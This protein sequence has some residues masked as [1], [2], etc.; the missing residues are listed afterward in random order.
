MIRRSTSLCQWYQ[1]RN[2][3]TIVSPAFIPK[4]YRPQNE[5]P[6][7][8]SQDVNQKLTLNYEKDIA[9]NEL[10]LLSKYYFDGEVS[11]WSL[12]IEITFAYPLVFKEYFM[13]FYNSYCDIHKIVI[14]FSIGKVVKAKADKGHGRCS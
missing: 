5:F 4:T 13:T 1:S 12:L 7:V 6:K 10:L 3:S 11:V 2:R 14:Y 9:S 8:I